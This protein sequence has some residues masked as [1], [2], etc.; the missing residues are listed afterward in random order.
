MSDDDAT[1]VARAQ[2]GDQLAF[3]ALVRRMSCLLFARLYLATGDRHRARIPF[4]KRGCVPI[5]AQTAE[6]ARQ[7]AAVAFDHRPERSRRRSPRQHPPQVRRTAASQI[8]LPGRASGARGGAGED[9]VR[10]EEVRRVL[11]VLRVAGGIS[12]AAVAALPGRAGLRDDRGA[13]GLSNGAARPAPSRT[14]NAATVSSRTR[15]HRKTATKFAHGARKHARGLEHCEKENGKTYLEP[16]NQCIA[17]RIVVAA[18][19]ILLLTGIGAGVCLLLD[20]TKAP[21]RGEGFRRSNLEALVRQLFLGE[22]PARVLVAKRNLDAGTL[23]ANPSEIFELKPC[24]DGPPTNALTGFDKLKGKCLMR[25]LRKGDRVRCEDLDDMIKPV[26]HMGFVE[27]PIAMCIRVSNKLS[28]RLNDGCAVLPALRVDL[29][30]TPR[31]AAKRRFNHKSCSRTCYCSRPE[32][33]SQSE[34]PYRKAISLWP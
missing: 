24:G 29:I 7:P 32:S 14:E 15:A 11:E 25:T 3:E 26:I 12:S 20:G 6:P 30:W 4:R 17:A 5:A 2:T 1:L 33:P 8:D 28:H 31:R 13:V 22:K 27:G 23:V 21:L 19:A 9:A 18:T 34:A 16:P 10:A